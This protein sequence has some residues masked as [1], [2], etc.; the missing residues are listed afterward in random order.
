MPRESSPSLNCTSAL[1][2][3]SAQSRQDMNLQSCQFSQQQ[4]YSIQLSVYLRPP[5]KPS[6]EGKA[7]CIPAA[8]Q[9]LLFPAH[10]S[11][12]FAKLGL[13][14]QQYSRRRFSGFEETPAA[15]LLFYLL[16]GIKFSGPLLL[17]AE[18]CKE[19]NKKGH[20]WK[21]LEV[22]HTSYRQHSSVQQMETSCKMMLILIKSYEFPTILHVIS[23]LL[24]TFAPSIQH[25]AMYQT[26]Y[27][28]IGLYKHIIKHGST[29]E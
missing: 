25:L 20:S 2:L 12:R 1:F 16:L 28:H 3:L 9:L 17:I 21:L 29:N 7:Q 10:T 23:Q 6:S 14:F 4:D 26:Y 11:L 19:K 24:Q 15:Y 8:L 18:N 13:C 22:I 5:R 27:K